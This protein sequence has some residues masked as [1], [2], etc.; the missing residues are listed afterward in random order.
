MDIQFI[1]EKSEFLN[2]YLTKYT[3]KSEECNIDFAM[4]NSNKPLASK[5]RNFTMRLNNRECGALEAA[6]TLLGIPCM[7]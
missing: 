1:E 6:D 7:V 3:T 5:L 4:I 2:S